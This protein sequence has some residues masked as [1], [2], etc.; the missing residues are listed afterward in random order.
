MI[1]DIKA[2]IGELQ[3]AKE[4]SD[5][6]AEVAHR[7]GAMPDNDITEILAV[8]KEAQQ[9]VTMAEGYN[10]TAEEEFKA[11]EAAAAELDKT[12]QYQQSV[13]ANL[14]ETAKDYAR[15]AKATN[16]LIGELGLKLAKAQGA[17]DTKERI[18][19]SAATIAEQ[20]AM[21]LAI[22]LEKGDQT[23]I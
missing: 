22:A 19:N 12:L 16:A 6:A 8:Q 13:L 7:L 11:A 20:A 4:K 18:A 17:L 5:F 2:R 15:K 21:A 1:V 23:S 9:V 3:S 10:T 14:D